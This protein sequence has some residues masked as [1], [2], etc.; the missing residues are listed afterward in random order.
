ML[1]CHLYDAINELGG[2]LLSGCFTCAP[3]I[4]KVLPMGNIMYFRRH[5]Y[6]RFA[7]AL[8]RFQRMLIFIGRLGGF[9]MDFEM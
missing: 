2:L 9:Q 6:K 8:I 3:P 5:G 1:R 7:C 4:K